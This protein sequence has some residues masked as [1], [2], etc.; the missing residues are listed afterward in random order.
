MA[1]HPRRPDIVDRAD[2]P[3]KLH[4]WISKQGESIDYRADEPDAG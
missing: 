3:A 4:R 2:V 1:D